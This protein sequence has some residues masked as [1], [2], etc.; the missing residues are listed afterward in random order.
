MHLVNEECCWFK[1]EEAKQLCSEFAQIS[2]NEIFVKGLQKLKEDA[3]E[4]ASK[5]KW[6][7]RFHGTIEGAKWGSW[8]TFRC[9]F[10]NGEE[11]KNQILGCK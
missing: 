7:Q 4:F 5:K 3:E 8:S 9:F 6:I 11:H 10:P 2:S 1:V